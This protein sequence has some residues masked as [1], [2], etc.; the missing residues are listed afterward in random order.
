MP[1]VINT[2]KKPAYGEAIAELNNR[3]ACD[4]CT[5]RGAG[6]SRS[7]DPGLRFLKLN[8]CVGLSG[9]VGR[10]AGEIPCRLPLDRS[11]MLGHL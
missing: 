4:H 6:Q 10:R 1:W 11:M 8:T 9:D 3:L 2:D 7:V 5:L